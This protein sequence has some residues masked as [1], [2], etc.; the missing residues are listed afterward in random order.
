MP[1][2]S[3]TFKSVS[4]TP[5]I[6]KNPSSPE[7]VLKSKTYSS[8]WSRPHQFTRAEERF[9]EDSWDRGHCVNF[10]QFNP[11]W[12]SCFRD[13]FD[14]PRVPE[15]S[16]MVGP[17]L[18]EPLRESWNLERSRSLPSKSVKVGSMS[19]DPCLRLDRD[20]NSTAARNWE[21]RRRGWNTSHQLTHS[22]GNKFR[23]KD[24][25]EFFGQ[26]QI[27][28]N[29][30]RRVL[31]KQ[32]RG[33]TMPYLPPVA[34]GTLR[35]TVEEILGDTTTLPKSQVKIQNASSERSQSGSCSVLTDG[36]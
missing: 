26:Y 7:F 36:Q 18:V 19:K 32:L 12:P 10:S 34:D 11:S 8:S 9:L 2:K 1:S 22:A 6:C 3:R 20:A 13:Y 14:R 31:D 4:G 29:A 5:L 35:Y 21:K 15:A 23:H 33:M 30:E 27:G 24:D 25:R 28:E 17:K 16:D